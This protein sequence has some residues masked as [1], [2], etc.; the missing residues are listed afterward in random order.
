MAGFDIPTKGFS[1]WVTK[2]V[3]NLPDLPQDTIVLFGYLNDDQVFTGKDLGDETKRTRYRL[4]LNLQLD[5]Y[6]VIQKADIIWDHH[7]PEG[8][9]TPIGGN[10][11]WVQP[12]AKMQYVRTRAS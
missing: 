1:D 4:Y 9:Y 8:F 10:L 5:E 6:L 11:L 3:K 2:V 7:V 12:G